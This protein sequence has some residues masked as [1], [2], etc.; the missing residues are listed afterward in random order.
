MLFRSSYFSVKE[1]KIN[2]TP[3]P[4][5]QLTK[6]DVISWIQDENFSKIPFFN[7]TIQNEIQ[8][9]RYN[10]QTINNPVW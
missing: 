4:F 7:K 9:K 10:E 6:E 2:S 3:T 5:D 1:P 8:A